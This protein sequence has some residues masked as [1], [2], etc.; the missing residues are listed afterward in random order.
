M[1]YLKGAVLGVFVLLSIISIYIVFKLILDARIPERTLIDSQVIGSDDIIN[2]S[3]SSDKVTITIGSE[4]ISLLNPAFILIEDKDGKVTRISSS[5]LHEK[6]E[7]DVIQKEKLSNNTFKEDSIKEFL[8]QIIT[9]S[10]SANAGWRCTGP[11]V[12]SNGEIVPR[13][14]QWI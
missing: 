9:A 2:S 4:V 12:N 13:K 14:C 3:L 1:K 11:Y 10:G 5:K 8:L 7:S 6:M